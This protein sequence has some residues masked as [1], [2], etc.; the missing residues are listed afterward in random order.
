[1]R[2]P[3]KH[4]EIIKAWADGA[5]IEFR[6]QDATTWTQINNRPRWFDTT[7]YRIK[8]N[9]VLINGVECAAPCIDISEYRITISSSWYNGPTKTLAFETKLDAHEVFQALID[10]F[11]GN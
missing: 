8:P 7:E 11:K 6:N 1:M 5:E 10:P 3:H 9:T 4:S 2:K